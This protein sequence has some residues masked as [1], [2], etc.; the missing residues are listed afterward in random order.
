M[1]KVP[2]SLQIRFKAPSDWTL[3]NGL[4]DKFV[5]LYGKEVNWKNVRC[6]L[7]ATKT[8]FLNEK[9]LTVDENKK[10]IH[11]TRAKYKFAL[12]DGYKTPKGDQIYAW[13]QKKRDGGFGKTDI[14]TRFDFDYIIA[15]NNH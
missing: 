1:N 4:R 8:Y 15:N 3:P 2:D 12:F 10:I 13:R 9:G 7:K 5:Y 6:A 11:R 14:G